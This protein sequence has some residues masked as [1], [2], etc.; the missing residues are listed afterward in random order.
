V[1]RLVDVSQAASRSQR[2]VLSRV[3]ACSWKETLLMPRILEGEGGD[4]GAGVLIWEVEGR[5]LSVGK[6]M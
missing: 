2:W 1:E 5:C 4:G 3:P 6:E